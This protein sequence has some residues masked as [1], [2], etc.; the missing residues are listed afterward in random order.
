MG[1]CGPSS[2]E[3]QQQAQTES[4]ENTLLANYNSR[5]AT[6]TNVL[7]GINS[8]LQSVVSA[9]P[10]QQG[11]SPQELA[12]YNTQAINSAGAANRNAQQ[13]AALGPAA[14]TSSGLQSG[15]QSAIRAGIG[16]SVANQLSGAQL[17]ITVANGQQGRTNYQNALQGEM[18]VAEG[19][20]PNASAA[21]TA[22]QSNFNQANT[23]QN[24]VGQEVS[25][26][27]GTV[28]GL[29]TGGSFGGGIAQGAQFL[30]GTEGA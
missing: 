5:F 3:K 30:G 11:F 17:G 25:G 21:L 29:L 19:E 22:G 1:I 14:Q 2:Q 13:Q 10:D 18:G 16:S 12:A 9:G 27:A 26:I 20:A 24:E 23:I 15:I 7:N 4:Y 28:G 8:Q 6:Q